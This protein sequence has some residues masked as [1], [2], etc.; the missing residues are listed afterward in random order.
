M[1]FALTTQPIN[2]GTCIQKQISQ[3]SKWWYRNLSVVQKVRFLKLC[4]LSNNKLIFQHVAVVLI[5]SVE[6]ALWTNTLILVRSISLIHFQFVLESL[7]QFSKW[8]CPNGFL[9][10][11]IY[12]HKKS[13]LFQWI[14]SYTATYNSEKS[15]SI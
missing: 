3:C 2:T 13:E 11:R 6:Q 15:D 8:A 12:I 14:D 10:L 7:I 5:I 9:C 1:C 4:K